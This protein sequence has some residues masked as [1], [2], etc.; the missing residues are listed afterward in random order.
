MNRPTIK[1]INYNETIDEISLEIYNWCNEE[2]ELE[3]IK[4]DLIDISNSNYNEDGYTLA[5]EFDYKGYSSDSELVEILDGISYSMHV[6][7]DKYIKKWVIENNILPKKN[8]GDIV[9]VC[10]RNKKYIGE[11]IKIYKEDAKYGIFI[12]SEGFVR[13]GS[14][15][16]NTLIKY[17]DIEK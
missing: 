2:T 1:D 14:G 5:K 13:T 8:I 11:I 6:E 12:E 10:Y 7:Y 16:H 4:E 9:D 17:E 3:T 15:T